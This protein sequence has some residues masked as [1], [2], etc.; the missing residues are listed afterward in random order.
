MLLVVKRWIELKL[1]KTFF[2][3]IQKRI[4]LKS[5]TKH[6]AILNCSC[7]ENTPHAIVKFRLTIVFKINSM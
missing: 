3:V 5:S 7:I 1:R 4:S 6:D 2:K